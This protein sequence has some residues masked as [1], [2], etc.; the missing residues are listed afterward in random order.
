MDTRRRSCQVRHPG[1]RDPGYKARQVLFDL[2]ILAQR[3][4]RKLENAEKEFR[5]F[6]AGVTFSILMQK[7]CTCGED[8]KRR[9]RKI[10]SAVS[11]LLCVPCALSGARTTRQTLIR[12]PELLAIAT[13]PHPG[14]KSIRP[15]ATPR[16]PG[17]LCL[18]SPASADA[19]I[20]CA[21]PPASASDS[22]THTAL[23]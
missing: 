8:I 6:G 21:P 17:P 9:R 5:A 14:R 7:R 12:S 15:R 3:T 1:R 22:A 19:P 18:P 13:T 10:L 23:P 2:P 16:L 4:Q 11:I 20:H